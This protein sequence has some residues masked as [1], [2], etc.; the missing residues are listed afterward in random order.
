VPISP[1]PKLGLQIQVKP[2]FIE[3]C[4]AKIK[5]WSKFQHF[6]DRKPPWVKLYRELLDDIEWHLLEPK[7]AKVLTTLWLIASEYDGNLPDNKTLAFRLR[8]S[9]KETK[10][11]VSKLGHWLIQD[12][13]NTISD[14]YQDD[15]LETERETETEKETER[16]VD[17]KP[18]TSAKSQATRLDADW[19]LPDDWAIWAKQ[20]RP[21]LNVNA[22]ADGFKDYWISQPGVKGRKADW[23]ATW[24]NWIRN[25]KVS[26]K[27]KTYESPWQKADRLRMQELAP[28]VATRAHDDEMKTIDEAFDSYKR[29]Q[30]IQHD[31][32]N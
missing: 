27:D 2:F 14:R 29:P 3:V 5:N 26:A 6:K 12:D 19:E 20:E 17:A 21:E 13:I 4:M 16:E 18:P 8:L 22:I 30:R 7:A 9:E 32:A 23:F 25:Q 31:I 1:D 10:D 11:A 24:R 28:G 15:S